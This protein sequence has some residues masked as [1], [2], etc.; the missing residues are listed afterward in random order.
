MS[1]GWARRVAVATM[2]AVVVG[3]CV[4]QA[5]AY[6]GPRPTDKVEI[7]VV[8]VNG[9][10]CRAGSALVAVSPDNTAFTVTYSNYLAQVGPDAKKKD[11]EKDCKISLRVRVP[12]D[13]T[14][15]IGRTDY[16]GFAEL[17]SGVTARQVAKYYF[18]GAGKTAAIQHSFAGPYSDYWQTTDVGPSAYEPCGKQRHLNI[19]TEL[20]VQAGSSDPSRTNMMAMDATDGTIKST[21]QLLWRKCS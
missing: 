21:Y 9:S 6:A 3:W 18:N 19:D 7:D 4:P 11:A 17:E 12:R 20:T 10:G 5:A 13:F 2:G 8:K 1:N 15:A 16:R 14:Y